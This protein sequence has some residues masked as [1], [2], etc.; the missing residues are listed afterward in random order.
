MPLTGMTS[1]LG[2]VSCALDQMIRG[3]RPASEHVPGVPIS[4]CTDWPGAKSTPWVAVDPRSTCSGA[5]APSRAKV[6]PDARYLGLPTSDFSRSTRHFSMQTTTRHR[7]MPAPTSSDRGATYWKTILFGFADGFT[8]P[9]FAIFW[10]LVIAWVVCPGRHPIT[11]LSLLAEPD[12]RRAHD[13]YHRF[14]RIGAWS[15]EQLWRRLAVMVVQG[16]AHR[17]SCGWPDTTFQ[18]WGRKVEGSGRSKDPVRS[19]AQDLVFVNRLNLVSV[20]LLPP[21]GGGMPLALPVCVR[22]YRQQGPT[23]IEPAAAML[24]ELGEWLPERELEVVAD[25]PPAHSPE[26]AC[27]GWCRWSPKP[28][29]PG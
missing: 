27:R 15:L 20:A 17:A 2:R 12:G 3:M 28:T 10:R 25:G 23:P 8:R 11:R 21:P 1:P 24:R 5:P 13:A 26:P 18:R 14:L 19:T 7:Q 22:R 16:S 6:P 29:W 9:F 4:N